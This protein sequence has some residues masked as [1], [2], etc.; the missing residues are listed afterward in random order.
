MLAV[1]RIKLAIGAVLRE[2]R[3]LVALWP[4][5]LRSVAHGHRGTPV[6]E[7]NYETAAQVPESGALVD[8][9]VRIGSLYCE[10]LRY[11]SIAMLA[12][13]QA[14]RFGRPPDC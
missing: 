9:G 8:R 11:A 3:V 5:D 2:E 10:N 14:L 1:D 13:P 6:F 12:S 7:P 4:P